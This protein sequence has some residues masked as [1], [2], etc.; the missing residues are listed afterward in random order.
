MLSHPDTVPVPPPMAL[1]APAQQ[2]QTALPAQ[3]QQAQT[4]LPAPAQ[5]AQT[6][7]PA[8][9][10]QAQRSTGTSQT[11]LP[12][13]AQQAQTALPTPPQQTQT[14][15]PTPAQQT[16]TTLP[17]PAQQEETALLAAAQK[18]Q[19]APSTITPASTSPNKQT[20]GKW[21]R[22]AAYSPSGLHTIQAAAE[23]LRQSKRPRAEVIKEAVQKLQRTENAVRERIRLVGAKQK[24]S[25]PALEQPAAQRGRP[26]SSKLKATQ[27]VQQQTRAAD[28]H[29]KASSGSLVSAVGSLGDLYTEDT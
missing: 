5:Q 20:K 24:A 25:T 18:T 2:T 3:P 9:P 4:A 7:L 1:P 22:A 10:Q 29:S 21:G 16:Q 15:L 14:A 26:A 13:P 19:T 17:A 27:Q 12:A 11:A 6:A 23:E 8:Q 28:A